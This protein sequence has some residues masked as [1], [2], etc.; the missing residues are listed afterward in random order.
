MRR[1]GIRPTHKIVCYSQT[2]NTI[3]YAARARFILKAWGYLDVVILSG[4]LETWEQCQYPTL[5]GETEDCF[6]GSPEGYELCQKQHDYFATME[7]I[8]YKIKFGGMGDF[9]QIIDA[10]NRIYKQT[11][12]GRRLDHIPNAYNMEVLSMLY[13]SGEMKSRSE[14]YSQYRLL[15]IFIYIYIYILYRD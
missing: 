14:L 6:D 1:L 5:P 8:V 10:T 7:D 12:P 9:P 13:M 2:A 11:P 15:G 3:H 4:S